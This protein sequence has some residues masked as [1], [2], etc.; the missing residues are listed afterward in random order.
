MLFTTVLLL[1]AQFDMLLFY[2]AIMSEEEEVK[3]ETT[4]RFK[5]TLKCPT[6]FAPPVED[7][8]RATSIVTVILKCVVI[9]N[10]MSFAST[11]T[12]GFLVAIV[13]LRRESSERTM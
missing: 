1:Y 13:H 12:R 3:R 8:S 6:F 4:E 5:S 10:P 7:I 9:T 2:N 11:L